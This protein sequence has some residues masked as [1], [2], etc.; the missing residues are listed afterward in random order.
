MKINL[1]EK[2]VGDI[3]QIDDDQRW[4]K[5]FGLNFDN[6]KVQKPYGY[7]ADKDTK[8]EQIIKFYGYSFSED[9]EK[10]ILDDNMAN[11]LACCFDIHIE[12][13][14]I[15]SSPL[16]NIFIK[17]EIRSLWKFFEKKGI[18][19]IAECK[20]IFNEKEFIRTASASID[21][22]STMFITYPP[23]IACSRAKKK[24]IIDCLSLKDI[25]NDESEY[26][27]NTE[28]TIAESNKE[29]KDKSIEK[30]K[31][32]KISEAQINMIKQLLKKKKQKFV[33]RKYNQM[34][35]DEAVSEI[36]KLK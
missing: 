34:T 17:P 19:Y 10:W 23:E 26:F 18:K 36:Q 5:V 8:K 16:D 35:Y 28:K 13:Q 9:S 21:N 25:I 4:F 6:I 11:Y 32:K 24:C 12:Y 22:I 27:I 29:I 31:K 20:A 15:T 30:D 1:D 2:N 7:I 14:K 3:F 33:K